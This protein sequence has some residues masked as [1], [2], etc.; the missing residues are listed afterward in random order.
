MDKVTG[1]K[2]GTAIV[3]GLE[4]EILEIFGRLRIIDPVRDRTINNKVYR[5]IEDVERDYE[6]R[7]CR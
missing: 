2:V 6:V 5:S 4:C 1:K 3:N 7:R